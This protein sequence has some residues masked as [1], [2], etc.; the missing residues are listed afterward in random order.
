MTGQS[1][2]FAGGQQAIG[3]AWTIPVLLAVYLGLGYWIGGLLGA[4]LAGVVVG[5]LA[6]MGAVAYEIRKVLCR[7]AGNQDPR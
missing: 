5:W 3:L 7:D 4:R 6:G 1:P 2:F